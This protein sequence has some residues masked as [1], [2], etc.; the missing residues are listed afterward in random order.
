MVR[1]RSEVRAR[2]PEKEEEEREGSVKLIKVEFVENFCAT[3]EM[4]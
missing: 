3:V 4:S 1:A 2:G